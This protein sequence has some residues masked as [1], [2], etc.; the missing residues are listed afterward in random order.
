MHDSRQ[1]V[2]A[3]HS[4]RGRGGDGKSVYLS[5]ALPALIGP[6]NVSS[7]KLDGFGGN[8]FALNDTIGKALNVDPDVNQGAK[9]NEGLFKS[10]AVGERVQFELK[11]KE[12]LSM[13]PTAKVA[14]GWNTRPRIRDKSQGI[15][16]RMLLVGF[17]Q[18]CPENKRVASMD[19]EWYWQNSGELPG[20][21]NW[22]I[23]GLRRLYI[24]GGFTVSEAMRKRITRIPI[25]PGSRFWVH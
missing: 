6:S 19:T 17:E 11:G 15:W 7:V 23:R 24:Q 1:P 20:I 16:R 18:V 25:R 10:F 9:F 3:V 4:T 13:R 14:L 22:G 5:G 12:P 21:F 2:S 8:Q